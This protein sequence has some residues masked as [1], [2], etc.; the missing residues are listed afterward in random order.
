MP[1]GK[2]ILEGVISPGKLLNIDGWKEKILSEHATED[3][4]GKKK[5][6]EFMDVNDGDGEYN[7][8]TFIVYEE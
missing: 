8:T 1:K 5:S 7:H 4:H 2:V 3:K 6:V